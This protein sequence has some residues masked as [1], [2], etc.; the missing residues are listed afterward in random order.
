VIERFRR[1]LIAG[2][3]TGIACTAIAA[4]AVAFTAPAMAASAAPPRP[5]VTLGVAN[6]LP[7]G[8][9]VTATT[10]GHATVTRVSATVSCGTTPVNEVHTTY[11]GVLVWWIKMQTRWCW[12]GTFVTSH[13]TKVSHWDAGG[14]YHFTGAPLKF[15]CPDG[16]RENSESISK[17]P[18]FY[19]L[20]GEVGVN[21][22][23]HMW[24]NEFGN[25]RWNAG[26][27][28]VKYPF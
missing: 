19:F 16:C 4:F 13:S 25:G 12:N 23:V 28:V 20:D 27:H 17:N 3:I 15:S 21:W 24:Q 7:A 14:D 10:S 9:K 22:D 6:S 2:A 26:W 1:R 8:F 5:Q 18:M 11:F